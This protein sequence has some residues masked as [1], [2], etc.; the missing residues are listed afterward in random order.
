MLQV[1]THEQNVDMVGSSTETDAQQMIENVLSSVH[2]P[3]M[4][5]EP[6]MLIVGLENSS[7]KVVSQLMAHA[8][9]LTS[10]ARPWP[11]MHEVAWSASKYA[12]PLLDHAGGLIS[13]DGYRRN[14]AV[15]R[16]ALDVIKVSSA[17][18]ALHIMSQDVEGLP[19]RQ[20]ALWAL[21]EPSLLY[22]LPAYDN[23]YKKKAKYLTVVVDPRT[24]CS[25]V[26][27][28]H[29]SFEMFGPHVQGSKRSSEDCFGW[30]AGVM[31]NVLDIYERESRFKVVRFEDLAV[32]K[33][34]EAPDATGL[35]VLQCIAKLSDMPEPTNEQ[36]QELLTSARDPMILRE[37]FQLG[38][39]VPENYTVHTEVEPNELARLEASLKAR[40]AADPSVQKALSR[41]G[42][43]PSMYGLLPAQSPAVCR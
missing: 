43:S 12:I 38:E 31:N 5:W 16:N 18:T 42:Y 4:H 3:G 2:M 23:V 21:Q 41:L 11:Y 30:W 26:T 35:A 13:E 20:G 36:A 25:S 33:L 8:G 28:L 7:T 37:Q 32:P 6:D 34:H 1:K 14:G 40:A 27:N 19:W 17:S 29:D 24:T 15:W 9:Y 22:L 39:K 10:P